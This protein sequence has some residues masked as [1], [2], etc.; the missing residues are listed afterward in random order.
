[1]N[2]TL[3]FESP[4]FDNH[5]H[6]NEM[7]EILQCAFSSVDPCG[8]VKQ[9]VHFSEAGLQ[10]NDTTVLFDARKD[11]ILVWGLGKASQSMARGLKSVLGTKI[12]NG[13]LITKHANPELEKFL[14]PDIVTFEGSHPIPSVKSIN[15]VESSMKRIGKLHN[16][17][18]VIALISGG[19]SALAIC[20]Q[21]GIQLED[22]QAM[23]K[24]L[25]DCGATI[26]EINIIRKQIDRIKGGGL[27]KMLSPARVVSLILSD[28]IGDPLDM[29]ASG[30]TVP[31]KHTKQEA[32]AVIEKYGIKAKVPP[33]I[34]S[35]LEREDR[36]DTSD[37][38]HEDIRNFLV[39]SNVMAA[40]AAKEAA[41]RLGFQTEVVSTN[42]QGEARTVGSQLGKD[43]KRKI[44]EKPG[45]RCWIY[46]G[47]TTVTIR[48]SGKGG[49]NQE[50]ALSAAQELA[51]VR[52]GC[53]LSIATDGEDGP[54]DAAGA[55]ADGD[56]LR[57]GAS[58]GLDLQEFLKNNDAYS[59]FE[60]V[61]G[62]IKTG[63]SGTN[64]NDLV[65][66]LAF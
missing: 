44:E 16:E 45:K 59:Y 38:I 5:L 32:R 30:P 1:M 9:A 49:R 40:N 61:G 47:E 58:L 4:Y 51:G 53:I 54:T 12:S 10:I 62:L 56:T 29:I 65:L 48:G 46:G 18:L 36:T 43:L 28:V 50:L 55:V 42:L 3:L 11:K 14:L 35:F 27:A 22:Y 13:T 8:A 64:V 52:G 34:R 63:P 15:A 21:E 23:T 37:L 17:D 6:A 2:T 19:G 7:V 26:H 33:A 57:V 20:P 60:R 66:L 39:G 41:L 24:A 25:L 31:S